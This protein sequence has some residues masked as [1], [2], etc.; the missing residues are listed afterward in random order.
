MKIHS[1]VDVPAVTIT[2]GFPDENGT[3]KGFAHTGTGDTDQRAEPYML[4]A[5]AWAVVVAKR[6][7]KLL[8]AKLAMQA[9]QEARERR[10]EAKMQ[11][12]LVPVTVERGN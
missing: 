12:L 8:R 6:L 11:T 4:E 3:C 7:R 5:A 1:N 10:K 9:V 2:I